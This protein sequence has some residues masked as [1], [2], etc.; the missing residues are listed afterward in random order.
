MPSQGLSL[1]PTFSSSGSTGLR[2]GGAECHSS[3]TQGPRAGAYI[4]ETLLPTDSTARRAAAA[5]GGRC[6]LGLSFPGLLAALMYVSAPGLEAPPVLEER[7]EA[8][9][10]QSPSLLLRHELIQAP[11]TGWVAGMGADVSAEGKDPA[12]VEAGGQVGL[13]PHLR[14]GFRPCCPQTSRYP[15][16]PSSGPLRHP[17][18][19]SYF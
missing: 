4:Q 8:P 13:E 19:L 16:P 10:L 2:P 18:A 17:Q 12:H 15:S 6:C 7:L 1:G 11:T 14:T 9:M 3:E 5:P